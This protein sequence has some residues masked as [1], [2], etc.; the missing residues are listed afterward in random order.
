MIYQAI[1]MFDTK[2]RAFSAEQSIYFE[3]SPLGEKELV[4]FEPLLLELL[5]HFSKLMQ[6]YQAEEATAVE[7][8]GS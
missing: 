3:P 6:A 4:H 1:R 7:L 5:T 2:Q 8:G